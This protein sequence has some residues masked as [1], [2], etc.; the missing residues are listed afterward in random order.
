M[1]PARV[2]LGLSLLV[3][4]CSSQ[5]LAPPDAGGPGGAGGRPGAGGFITG[6]VD[7]VTVRGE[8]QA[9]SYWYQGL[10]EG[11]L[12]AEGSTAEWTWMLLINNRTGPGACSYGL[13]APAGD[14]TRAFASYVLPDGRCD[15][16]VTATAPNVGDNLEGTFTA[17]LKRGTTVKVVTNGA[18]RVPRIAEPPPSP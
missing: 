13:L 10:L 15:V 1:T 16:T 6:D 12:L 11:W 8:T 5:T 14:T 4:A 2:A 7:G 17:T 3:A 9:V 18:F